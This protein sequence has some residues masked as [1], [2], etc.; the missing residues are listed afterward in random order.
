MKGIATKTAA[1]MIAEIIDIRRF[2]REESLACYTGLGIRTGSRCGWLATAG[3]P[4]S[5]HP[6][7]CCLSSSLLR[8]RARRGRARR[9][10]AGAC[11]RAMQ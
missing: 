8:G 1:K 2:A 9:G 3:S 5:W 7:T 4:C 6:E 11:S 10:R